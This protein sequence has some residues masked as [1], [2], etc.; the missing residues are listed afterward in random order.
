MN[1]NLDQLLA[2]GLGAIIVSKEKA[3]AIAEELIKEGKLNRG[4][5]NKVIT[6]LVKRGEQSKQELR[7]HLHHAVRQA[8]AELDI[9][10]RH[11]MERLKAEVAQLKKKHAAKPRKK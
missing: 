8:L 2:L 10:S 3:Q 5:A 4:Q 1:K 11:E 9:P 7:G 6:Q